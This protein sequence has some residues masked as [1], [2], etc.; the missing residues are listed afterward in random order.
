MRRAMATSDPKSLKFPERD[1][2]EDTRRRLIFYQDEG[3]YRAT[4]E[5]NHPMDTLYYL[6]IIDILTPYTVKKKIERIWKGMKA[7]RVRLFTFECSI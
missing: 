1:T 4:D 3:G 7:D 6:G 5:A 2:V